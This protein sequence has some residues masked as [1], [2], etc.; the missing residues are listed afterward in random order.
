MIVD[1][2]T[3]AFP[4]FL[5]PKAM[6]KLSEP[7][8]EFEPA[9]DGTLASLLE[10]MSVAGVELS[11]LANIATRPEQGPSIL[12]WSRA[13]VSERVV[14][15]GSIHPRSESW[16]QELDAIAEAAFPGI[17]FHA[18]YQGFAVDDDRMIPIYDRIAKLGMFILFHGGYDIAFPGDDSS[19]PRRLARV[20]RRVP[21]LR[22]IA[23]HTGGW[24]AFPEVVEHLLGTDVYLDT[25][26]LHELTRENVAIVLERHSTNRLLFASDTPWFS[27]QAALEVIRSLP[28][29]RAA[30]ERILGQNALELHP[31]LLARFAASSQAGKRSAPGA[32]DCGGLSC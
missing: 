5:A 4:D 16:E 26:Y 17:K 9:R 11:F 13:I 27:Q 25:S 18:Q 7:F 8:G 29:S 19:S 28:V 32:T 24:M 31:S 15:L 6:A 3:H 12:E 21:E 22:M 1:V 10:S 23:A 2:H 30:L 14:P 20:N